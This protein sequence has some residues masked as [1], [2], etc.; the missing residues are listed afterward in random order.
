VASAAPAIP[1][2]RV[3]RLLGEG[4]MGKV[5]LAEDEV[6]G[7]P[8]AVKTI[9][10]AVA[11]RGEAR[12]RF[13]REARAMA[14][15]EH[16][17]VVRVYS[18]GEREALAYFVME[19]VEGE[20]LVDR[21]RRA[22]I[23]VE[24]S[25][26]IAGEVAEG[27]DAAWTRGIVHRDVKPGN[28]LLDR[29]GHVHVADFGLARPTDLSTGS[30]EITREGDFVGSPHYMAPEQARAERTDFRSDIYSLGVVLYE[31]L[32]GRRPF[33]GKTPTEIV[34][35]HLHETPPSLRNLAPD[36][37]EGVLRLVEQ[38]TAKDPKQRPGSYSDVMSNLCGRRITAAGTAMPTATMPSG[39]ARLL[40]RPRRRW[41]WAAAAATLSAA[42]AIGV[43]VR[44]PRPPG[45]LV[46]AVAPFYGADRESATEGRA[47]ASLLGRE[48]TRRLGPDQAAAI[49]L[50]D[51]PDAL[52]GHAAARRLGSRLAADLV[53]WGEVLSFP[54]ETEI[55]PYL[56]AANTATPQPREGDAAPPRFSAFVVDAAAGSIEQRRRGAAVLVDALL[57]LAAERALERGGAR[58]ALELI[59]AAAPSPAALRTKAR[60]LE[61][62]GRKSEA[63]AAARAAAAER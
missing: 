63:E 21:L 42:L 27:L 50:V 10:S 51:A 38:M 28:I 14:T 13:L 43:P 18:F 39:A 53:V 55:Q 58:D 5:F 48:V 52:R 9:S 59:D 62:L 12:A 29:D 8:V 54:G 26:R 37:P 44:H 19:Y 57:R 32:A 6:L 7:R 49:A 41:P 4:G 35:K 20:A 11:G 25:V 40:R 47:F 16:P 33:E 56:T 24:E 23:G 17:R 3:L 22:P 34:A 1:G 2:Y 46:V 15:V 60:A 31:M 36:T 61:A 30:E 45:D